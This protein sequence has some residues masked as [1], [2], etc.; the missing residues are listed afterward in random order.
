MVGGVSG[1]YSIP[2]ADTRA[3]GTFCACV[4]APGRAALRL[5]RRPVHSMAAYMSTQVEAASLELADAH[6]AAHVGA[7]QVREQPAHRAARLLR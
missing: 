6:R 3:A 7:L 1:T 2:A 5:R 4:G